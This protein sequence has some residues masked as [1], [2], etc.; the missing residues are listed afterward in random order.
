MLALQVDQQVDHLGLDRD[1]ERGDRLVADDQARAA[2]AGAGEA[3][4][5]WNTICIARRCGRS[6]DLLRWVMSVPSIRMLPP[7]GSTKRSTLRATVDLPQPDSPTSP[8]VSPTPTEK[9]MPS[10]ACTVPAA[11]RSTPD[12]TG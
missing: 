4:G 6:S 3:N 8:S 9:L 12:R 7:V 5:S 1:V 2:R 11:R 10:T